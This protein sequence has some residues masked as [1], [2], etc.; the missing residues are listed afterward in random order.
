VVRRPVHERS[1]TG[2]EAHEAMI[3]LRLEV[4][5]FHLDPRLAGCQR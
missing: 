5:L 2:N 1:M 3:R 4:H